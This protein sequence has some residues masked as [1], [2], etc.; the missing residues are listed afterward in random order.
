MMA[1]IATL[2]GGLA[3]VAVM[4]EAVGT[5]ACLFAVCFFLLAHAV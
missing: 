3:C 1:T 2:L 5:A 4:L